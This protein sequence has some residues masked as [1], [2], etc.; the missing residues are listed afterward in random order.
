MTIWNQDYNQYVIELWK[1]KKKKGTPDVE[2]NLSISEWSSS[3][4]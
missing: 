2:V 4:V 3:S 1:K